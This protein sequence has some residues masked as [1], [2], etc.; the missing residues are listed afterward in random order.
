MLRKLTIA[1]YALIEQADIAFEKGL[2]VITGETG[3][4]KS[5]LLG[6]LHL[7]LGQRAD[8]SVLL[9]KEQKCV[10]EGV[11][12][13]SNHQLEGLFATEDVDYETL[14]VIRR[15]I[16]PG[17]KSRAFV[18]DTPVTVQFLK[19][20]GQKLIDI[21][22][23]HQTLLLGDDDYQLKIIDTLSVNE[24]LRDSYRKQ[25]HHYQSLQQK[26][27]E[28]IR[29]NEQLKNELD[30]STF[31][32]NQLDEAQ[33][34][35]GETTLLEGELERLSHAEEIQTGVNTTLLM[36]Q[37]DE[38]SVTSLLNQVAH[39]M[40]KIAAY[41]PPA[42]DTATRIESA[43]IDLA[44]LGRE[45]EKWSFSIDSDPERLQLLQQRLNLIYDLQKKHKVASTDELLEIKT[46][47]KAQIDK[48]TFFDQ[49]L[50]DL[51]KQS[52]AALQALRTLANQ[53]S[54]SRVAVFEA[55]QQSI[56]G[57]LQD[58]GMPNANFVVHLTK[59]PQFTPTGNDNIQFLFS[60]N[61]NGTP[62]PID[63]VASGGEM[64]RVMLSIKSLLSTAQELPTL[65]FDE[66]DTGV[67]G[68]VADKMGK[69]MHQ[70][71]AHLQVISITH[72]PQIAA[73]GHRHFKVYKTDTEH[74]TVSRI[75]QLQEHDRLH[76]IAKMLSGASVSEAAILNAKA[77][78]E[79]AAG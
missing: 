77:L 63:K 15:E 67:S 16:L 75:D 76:E 54:E 3:A 72:L 40:Q 44:D 8:A 73:R 74:Q 26:Q 4:G 59:E 65:I 20:L 43:R 37:R 78:L 51:E 21:H 11:F 50:S 49:E 6:A 61:K 68:E 39:Q 52:D 64:S 24:S 42:L 10:V 46:K 7:I 71:A 19:T 32:H 70:M 47:L 28:L 22:S 31:Q 13:L 53:L 33:L 25:Y 66:I 69:I 29:E 35:P 58:L 62:A 23:Q 57:R 48:A 27:L 17:G 18:N 56:T 60:A 9:N 12:D 30:Y 45:L 41:L 34:K 2:T 5:I 79:A 14:T 38:T 55:M 1:N 36:L